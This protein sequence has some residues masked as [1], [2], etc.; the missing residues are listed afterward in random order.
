MVKIPLGI[1]QLYHFG[2]AVHCSK[3]KFIGGAKI[4]F[5]KEVE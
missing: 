1:F 3:V 4:Q 2:L 5:F